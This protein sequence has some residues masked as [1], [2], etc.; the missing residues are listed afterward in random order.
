MEPV[1]SLTMDRRFGIVG[2]QIASVLKSST[3][4]LDGRF[5]VCNNAGGIYY[6]NGYYENIELKKCIYI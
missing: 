4:F 2:S 3:E 6:T 5:S 1:S